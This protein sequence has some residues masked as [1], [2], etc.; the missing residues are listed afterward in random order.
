LYSGV[1]TMKPS[2]QAIVCRTSSRAGWPL[3]TWRGGSSSVPGSMIASSNGPSPS[4]WEIAQPATL[5]QK[6]PSRPLP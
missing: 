2:A 4:I 5:S 1:T 6:R 3:P